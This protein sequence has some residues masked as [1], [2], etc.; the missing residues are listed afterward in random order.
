MNVQA[1]HGWKPS[2]SSNFSIRAFRA[3]PLVEM[4]LAAPCRASRAIQGSSIS[5]SS[6]FPPSWAWD[7]SF[8]LRLLSCFLCFFNTHTKTVW[9]N[10]YCWS[11]SRGANL[12]TWR[13]KHWFFP[14][15]ESTILSSVNLS[16]DMCCESNDP[17]HDRRERMKTAEG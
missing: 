8:V 7:M 6:T 2:S 9:L 3:Y 10:I 1:R 15:F 5:V 16:L 17:W 4:R 13:R 11:L 12:E 14:K